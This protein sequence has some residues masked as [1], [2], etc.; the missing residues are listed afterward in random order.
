MRN[1][2]YESSW[3]DTKIL[4]RERGPLT[5]DYFPNRDQE[6]NTIMFSLLYINTSHKCNHTASIHKDHR[7]SSLAA[8]TQCKRLKAE[9]ATLRSQAATI[10]ER[11]SYCHCVR[12]KAITIR[13]PRV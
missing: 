6:T 8:I 12:K 7:N 1:L 3:E 13:T 11:P 4:Q 5:N 2:L 9:K 10:S